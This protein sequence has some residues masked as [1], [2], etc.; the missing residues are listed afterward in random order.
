MRREGV[1]E[2][3]AFYPA[4]G[5]GAALAHW[6]TDVME[7]IAV[8]PEATLLVSGLID[9]WSDVARHRV[10]TI[11]DMDGDV[12]LGVPEAPNHILYL[13]YPIVD[14]GLP[15][16]AKLEA[17]ARL[18]A[19]LVKH[20]HVVLVHCLLGANRS[21]LLAATALT[22]LGLSGREA[23]ERM[24]QLNPGALFNEVFASHVAALP[25]R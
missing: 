4:C 19:D 5:G 8:N 17:V 9:D 15:C 25:A 14:D 13:Y 21:N 7:I 12:D 11:V 3:A 22:Y 24:R 2:H 23:L 6:R 1:G 18:V 20:E 10:D 16:L